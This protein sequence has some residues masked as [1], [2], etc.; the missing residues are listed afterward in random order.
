MYS[1]VQWEQSQ[2]SQKPQLQVKA[3]A[4]LMWLKYF[5]VFALLYL[6]KGCEMQCIIFMCGLA[7]CQHCWEGKQ[8]MKRVWACVCVWMCVRTCVC[9]HVCVSSFRSVITGI[10]KL[11][12]EVGGAWVS[13]NTIL[14]A[15]CCVCACVRVVCLRVC[16]CTC[17]CVCA[18]LCV[19][20]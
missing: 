4:P 13:M 17:A 8:Q 6:Q 16:V 5:P 20:V 3:S 18:C 10:L 7:S 2:K 11:I 19:C 15:A 14:G 12:I 9:T 1:P